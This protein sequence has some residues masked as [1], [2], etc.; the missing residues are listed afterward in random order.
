MSLVH[1]RTAMQMEDPT[2]PTAA[3]STL[4]DTKAPSPPATRSRGG[5]SRKTAASDAAAASTTAVAK[6]ARTSARKQKD[7][8]PRR[9]PHPPPSSSS[10]ESSPSSPAPS[11]AAS[12]PPGQD[13]KKARLRQRNREAAR[14]CRVR[15]Q[16]GIEDLQSN[17]AAVTAVHQALAAEATMLRSEVL[18]LKNMVLQ[19]GGCGC[20]Y[21]QSYIE[22]AAT[23]LLTRPSTSSTASSA[24]FTSPPPS[25]HHDPQ[26]NHTSSQ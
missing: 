7:S 6:P 11:V 15:K 23:R 5:Q 3:T 16:R 18:M 8:H 10:S 25:F 9:P 21:I 24:S 26:I 1:S 2:S 19:H 4:I 20:P 14:K 13:D 22:G 12:S 17:E